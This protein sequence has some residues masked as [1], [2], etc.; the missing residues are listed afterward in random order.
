MKIVLVAVVAVLA[1][2]FFVFGN[3]GTSSLVPGQERTEAISGKASM[4]QNELTLLITIGDHRLE[5][6][7]ENNKATSAL[8]ERLQKE[9][10]TITM[11]DYGN[12]EKVGDLPF[13][14][15]Q[16]NRELDTRP[17]DIILYQGKSFVI[18]Y[19][20]NHWSLTKLGKVDNM[21]E[22]ELR[23]LLKNDQVTVTLSL[24]EK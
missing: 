22:E 11:K 2:F 7:L 9:D 24:V 6:K 12:M 23:D 10:V 16:E 15:P 19:G 4:K 21:T 20:R 1:I 17:G 13:S 8:V 3:E 5:G 14:L 18:Y